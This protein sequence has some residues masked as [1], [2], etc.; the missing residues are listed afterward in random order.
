MQLLRNLY[1]RPPGLRI[2]E[3]C[4]KAF[5]VGRDSSATGGGRRGGWMRLEFLHLSNILIGG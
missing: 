2:P 1:T 3:D 4:A 5:K